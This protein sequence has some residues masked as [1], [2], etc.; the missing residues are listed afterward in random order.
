MPVTTAHGEGRAEFADEAALVACDSSG[1]VALR[2]ISNA[3]AV[4]QQF[5]ANPNGSPQGITA[6][7]N[8]DGRH[9]IMMPH[10]ERVYR[11]VQHSWRPDGWQEDGPWMR[12]FRN[13]RHWLG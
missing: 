7:T 6:V 12:L 1:H 8:A 3:G 5:P 4:T 10:P 13:A 9:T 11:A 2:Y